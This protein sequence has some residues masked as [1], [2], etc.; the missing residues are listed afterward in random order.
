MAQVYEQVNEMML[1]WDP[2]IDLSTIRDDLTC[3]TAGWFKIQQLVLRKTENNLGN[4]WKTLLHRLESASFHSQPFIKSGLR[5]N[6]TAFAAFHMTASLPGR[7]SEIT[8]IRYINTKL[9][10][11]N[12]FFHGGQMII[13]ISY[14]KARASNNYAFY[15][16]FLAKQMHMPRHSSSEFFF[17]DPSGKKK[18]L[19]PTQASSILKDL[20]QDL[21]TPWSL[22]LYRQAALAIAKQYLKK[23]IEK[24]NFYYP[25]DATDPIRIFAARAGHHPR[26]LL[27]T[28][29]IDRALL[30]RLQPELL[31]IYQRLST[32]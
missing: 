28:Y 27:T 14:N 29:A 26:M 2:S 4:I 10:I 16:E 11:R 18:H 13:I 9:A 23:L 3:R 20:T 22:S 1:G 32:I 21:T 8:S 24:T 19:S 31:D 5:L 12:V 25:S 7:G 15:I 30:E 6:K 17:L